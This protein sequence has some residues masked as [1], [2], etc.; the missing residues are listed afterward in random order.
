MQHILL[1]GKYDALIDQKVV[2]ANAGLYAL[3]FSS[4]STA[5][6]GRATRVKTKGKAVSNL[7]GGQT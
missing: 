3:T 7:L 6:F 4:D 2:E 5:H 1:Q